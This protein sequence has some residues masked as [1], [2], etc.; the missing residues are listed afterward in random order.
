MVLHMP[1][2]VVGKLLAGLLLAAFLI[3]QAGHPDRFAGRWFAA[4]MNASH[5]ALTD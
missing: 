4:R 2:I 5:S 3:R 1:W